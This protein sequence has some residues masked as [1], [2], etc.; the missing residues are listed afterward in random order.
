[1][2][3]VTHEIAFAREVSSRV[4]FFDAGL[5]AEIGE[6]RQVIDAPLNERTRQFL[7]KQ[8]H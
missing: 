3:L 7:A 6:P 2:V 4:A 8:I 5:I 1:M